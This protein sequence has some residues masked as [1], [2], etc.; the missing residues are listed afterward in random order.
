MIWF[1]ADQTSLGNFNTTSIILFESSFLNNNA[2][3]LINPEMRGT[4]TTVQL[5]DCVFERNNVSL[6]V[7]TLSD[8][9]L[10]MILYHLDAMI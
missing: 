4:I 1:I 5:H 2:R 7:I 9:S 3:Y 10:N 8:S 6:A